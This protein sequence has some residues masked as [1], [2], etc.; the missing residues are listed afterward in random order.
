MSLFWPKFAMASNGFCGNDMSNNPMVDTALG[1]IPVK[2]DAMVEWILPNLF[3]VAGGIS[4]L[5][6]IYGFILWATSEGDPKKVQAAQE[7][8][9]SS[10]KGL[11]FCIFGLFIMKLIVADIIKIPGF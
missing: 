10:I 4:F 9:T 6:M 1:C 8:V 3:S 7:T 2:F 11:L 5:L